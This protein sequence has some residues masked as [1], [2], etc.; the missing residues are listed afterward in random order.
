MVKKQHG[1]TLIELLVVVIIVA[2]LAA[3]GIPLMTGNMQRARM[4]EA[5]A[6]LG[7]IRA[8]LRIEQAENGVAGVAG[9][10]G[11]GLTFPLT[12]SANAAVFADLD[13]VAGDWTGHYFEDNDY[14]IEA[15]TVTTFC[16]GVAG[17]T[18]GAAPRGVEV[19]GLVRSMDQAGSIYTT[20]NC[21]GTA[22]N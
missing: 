4:S 12:I 7:A 20:V 5:D 19:N 10:G 21:A 8:A 3:V 15:A 16:V 13:S 6:G 14:T 17:D 1:F 2:I 9:V 11:G 22:I 18:A